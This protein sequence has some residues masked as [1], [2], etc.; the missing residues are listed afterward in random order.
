MN[1]AAGLSEFGAI[2]LAAGFSRRMGGENKLLKPLDGRP[3]VAYALD[4]VAAL[5]LGQVVAVAGDA[6]EAICALL[7]PVAA[8]IENDEA[9]DGMGRSIAK[10][11]AAMRADL[12][13]VFVVLGDMPFIEPGDFAR[14]AGALRASGDEAICVPVRGGRRG[15]P[16]LFGRAHLPALARLSGDQGARMLFSAASARLVEV[17]GCSPG[18][19]IDLDEPAA[20]AEAE[21]KLRAKRSR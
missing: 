17:D 9:A 2:V 15:H 4:T 3:L 12:R 21:R 11:A 16:V 1:A 10:G 14:L 18:I 6:A 7:P 19:V 20:F 13:G 8:L 5:G